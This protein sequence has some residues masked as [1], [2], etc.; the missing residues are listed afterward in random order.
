MI[1]LVNV[2]AGLRKWRFLGVTVF[3]FFFTSV[4]VVDK[5]ENSVFL[6]QGTLTCIVVNTGSGLTTVDLVYSWGIAIEFMLS[7]N[8]R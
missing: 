4:A 5:L 7:F 2:A 6:S 3:F 8:N 1:P